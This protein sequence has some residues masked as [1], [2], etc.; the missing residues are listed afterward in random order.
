MLRF[1]R[2]QFKSSIMIGICWRV[3]NESVSFFRRASCYTCT[4]AHYECVGCCF[5]KCIEPSRP[6]LELSCHR[7]YGQPLGQTRNEF[8]TIV[9]N[10][11]LVIYSYAYVHRVEYIRTSHVCRYLARNLP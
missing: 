4:Y 8:A 10:D 5:A 1:I 6:A 2:Y 9:W 7:R 3:E 11:C